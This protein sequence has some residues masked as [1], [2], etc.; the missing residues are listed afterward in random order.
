MAEFD[1]KLLE[2]LLTNQ[3]LQ[4]FPQ[5]IKEIDET[6]NTGFAGEGN[7]KITVRSNCEVQAIEINDEWYKS[8]SKEDLTN[9]IKTCINKLLAKATRE[10]QE[11]QDQLSENVRLNF[12]K[13][14]AGDTNE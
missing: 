3:D 10:K 12:L 13:N 1:S 2:S 7:I 9:A 6:S 5:K 11:A 4:S 8:A 14:L